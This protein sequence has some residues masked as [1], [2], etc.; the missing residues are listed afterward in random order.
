MSHF[1]ECFSFCSQ[2]IWRSN[3][4]YFWQNNFTPSH[5]LC[6][7][8]YNKHNAGVRVCFLIFFPTE[9]P[10]LPSSL[11][12]WNKKGKEIHRAS[13][14]PPDQNNS[15]HMVIDQPWKA[16]ITF[17]DHILDDLNS[18]IS[19][20]NYRQS[21]DRSIPIIDLTCML[22]SLLLPPLEV[23]MVLLWCVQCFFLCKL[24]WCSLHSCTFSR[25][26]SNV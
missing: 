11:V 20:D 25:T 1:L 18:W 8:G 26:A 10:K 24:V 21:I 16:L 12:P 2:F 15:I 14:S 19:T 17:T 13:S 23:H 5:I 4:C 6:C 9:H 7:A 3:I 22:H